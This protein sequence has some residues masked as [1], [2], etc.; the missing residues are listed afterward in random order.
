M[1]RL[2]VARH[3]DPHE[4]AENVKKSLSQIAVFAQNENPSAAI[5]ELDRFR[6]VR[7]EPIDVVSEQGRQQRTP[8]TDVGDNVKRT[9]G[10]LS[11][12]VIIM[13]YNI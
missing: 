4:I 5:E 7:V 1:G 3:A 13:I 8:E 12:L 11:T 9:S 10:Q 6:D 2:A